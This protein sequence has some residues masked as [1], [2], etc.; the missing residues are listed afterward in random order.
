MAGDLILVSQ[1]ATETGDMAIARHRNRLIIVRKE[2][3]EANDRWLALSSGKRL[4][5]KPEIVGKC[6]GIVWAGL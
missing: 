3:K 1:E 2:P 5:G 4:T 6:I